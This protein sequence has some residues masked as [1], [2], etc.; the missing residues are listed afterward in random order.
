MY[1]REMREHL[2]KML[3]CSTYYEESDIDEQVEFYKDRIRRMHLEEP[4][5]TIAKDIDEICTK[6]RD[7]RAKLEEIDKIIE[8]SSEGWK[9]K[10][11]AKIDLSILRVAVYEIHNA[12]DVPYKVAIN[13]AVEIAKIYGGDNS[14]GFV[15]GILAKV[16]K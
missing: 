6:F 16:V 8:E 15:N 5:D 14:F 10:R 9:I 4:E 11:M 3:Y 1:R 2:V 13:E 12:D 7:I